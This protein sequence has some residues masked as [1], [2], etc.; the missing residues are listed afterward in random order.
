MIKDWCG[1]KDDNIVYPT[2]LLARPEGRELA[3]TQLSQN[4]NN[5]VTPT[6]GNRTQFP[7]L[8]LIHAWLQ[9][10]FL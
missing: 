10:F 9:E 3:G 5:T 2:I 4:R 1:L 6:R 8:T 7:G